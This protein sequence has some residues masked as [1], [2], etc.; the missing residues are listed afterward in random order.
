MEVLKQAAVVQVQIV[1][2]VLLIGRLR[3]RD[4]KEGRLAVGKLELL[5]VEQGLVAAIFGH[6]PLQRLIALQSAHR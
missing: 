3:P 5:C 1:L 2:G 6:G 4:R